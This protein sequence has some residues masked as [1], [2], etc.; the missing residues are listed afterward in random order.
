M[1]APSISGS[2]IT[3]TCGD[4]P[5]PGGGLLPSVGALLGERYRLV[6]VI[7]SGGMGTVF[8]AESASV[9]RRCA[10]KFLRAELAGGARAASR[11]EREARLLA[12][13]EHEHI[14]AVFDFGWFDERTPYFVMEYLDGQTLRERLRRSGPLPVELSLELIGQACRAMARAHAQGVVHRDLKP[15]NMMLSEHSDGR[16]WLK[17][18]DFGVARSLQ[19]DAQLTP[20]GAELGTAHYMAPEQ[21]RGAREVD[22][23]ADVYALGAILYEMLGG[24]RVYEGASYNEVLFQVLTQPHVPL[25]RL[26]PSCPPP[27]LAVVERCLRKDAT[28]RFADAAELLAA[29]PE[30][31]SLAVPLAPARVPTR[32]GAPRRALAAV[33]L[34]LLAFLLGTRWSARRA[35]SPTAPLAADVGAPGASELAA[36]PAPLTATESPEIPAV[37]P[38]AA[39]A[40]ASRPLAPAPS[41]PTKPRAVPA[42]T[43]SI[44]APSRSEPAAAGALP[45]VTANPY[46]EP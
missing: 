32:V 1:A 38:G 40:A 15:D 45:F 18:L 16:P 5:A 6:R 19:L 8:E 2:E 43:R 46:P 27:L 44:S 3:R 7:G 20:T 17:I 42:P 34:A 14:T 13:L 4:A 21:A 39:A 25:E 33:A 35:P 41:T 29:L 37:R 11:F 12:R 24:R 36:A 26:L 30:L 28:E 10:I 9:G 31:R 23:R 22:A